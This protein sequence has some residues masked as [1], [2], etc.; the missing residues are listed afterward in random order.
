MVRP[1]S[2]L[3]ASLATAAATA[4]PKV[5][6]TRPLPVRK[7]LLFRQHEHLLDSNDLVLF[8]RPGAFA[9]DEW[10]SLRAQLAA[11][12][13]PPPP[14]AAAADSP[15][16]SPSSSASSSPDASTSS[17]PQDALKLTLLRPG[18]LPALLRSASSSPSSPSL[19]LSHLSHPSHLKGPL[20]VLTAPSLHPPTLSAVLSIL[21]KFS[22]TPAPNAPPP[23]ADAPPTE[24][25]EVLSSLVERQA[26]S[27]E[28]TKQVGDLPTLEVLRAQIVGL[29]SAPGSRITGVLGAR[30]REVGRTVEGF[31]VGL[32]DKEKP[33]AAAA[34]A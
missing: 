4:T 8:L 32:E 3:S 15:S 30:A 6:R 19:D 12:P 23:A 20:A 2:T 26:A 13:P 16:P 1:T 29:L 27:A 7:S 34:E 33:A 14:P 21:R 10:R 5:A 25:L 11:V 17:S 22:R 9:A 24:R 18:L 31:K 28:R